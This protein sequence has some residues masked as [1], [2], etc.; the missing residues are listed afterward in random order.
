MLRMKE[1][2][3]PVTFEQQMRTHRPHDSVYGG[4]LAQSGYPDSGGRTMAPGD[5]LTF[6]FQK[7]VAAARRPSFLNDHEPACKKEAREGRAEEFNFLAGVSGL[8][9]GTLR[10]RRSSYSYDRS[11]MM[12][13]IN[14]QK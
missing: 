1:L 9:D 12:L 6:V 13:R 14:S 4:S 10:A 8:A 5:G 7:T 11:A 3:D 2:E